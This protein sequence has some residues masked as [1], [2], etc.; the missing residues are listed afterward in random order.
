MVSQQQSFT[1]SI[2]AGTFDR[3]QVDVRET[4]G[5]WIFEIQVEQQRGT[6]DDVGAYVMDHDNFL[7]WQTRLQAGG[8]AV[9]V[10]QVLMITSAKLHWGT[11]SFRPAAL[12]QH[13][14]VL[15]NTHSSLTSKVV[16]V[17]AYWVSNESMIRKTVRESLHAFGW[18]DTWKLFERAEHSLFANHRAEACFNVRTAIATLWKQVAERNCGQP[19]L[20]DPG[21]STEIGLLQR[22]ME[23]YVPSYVLSTVR[24]SWSLASELA[25][26][27]KR[28]GLEPPL[29]QVMLALRHAY[30][31]AAF[32]VSLVRT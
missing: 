28:D 23:S 5:F 15:D 14:L 17:S 10:P 30:A 21:K 4:E 32:L 11:L 2:T 3:L 25:H 31:S 7:I 20:F 26:I 18:H 1:F 29:D 9:G 16:H 19:I 22:P 27:E 13:Y 12:G 6:L 8:T 24:Q